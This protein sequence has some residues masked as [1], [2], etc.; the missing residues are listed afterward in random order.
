MTALWHLAIVGFSPF[1]RATLESCLRLSAEQGSG[2]AI[3]GDVQRADVLIADTDKAG[4]CDTLMAAQLLENTLA[5]GTRVVDGCMAQLPRPIN[6]LLLPRLLDGL[7]ASRTPRLQPPAADPAGVPPRPAATAAAAPDDALASRF[8]GALVVDPSKDVLR[9][10]ANHLVRFGFAV[11]LARSGEEALKVIVDRPFEFVFLE[12]ALTGI[13]G[14][15]T[16][17]MIKQRPYAAGQRAPRVVA[18]TARDGRVDRV[19][20][21][22]AGCDAFLSKP[23]QHDALMAVIGEHVV[24]NATMA[25]TA[26]APMTQ[27]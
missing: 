11:R 26:Y 20:A 21:G 13:S 10:M 3:V 17:R 7:L 25:D 12:L 23:L 5:I 1:E 27:M 4:L 2:Y 9:F 16:C 24:A 6:P 8:P 19:R 18:M 15:E 22:L 14:F